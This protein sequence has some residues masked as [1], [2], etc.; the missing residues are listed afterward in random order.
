MKRTFTFGCSFTEYFW[1]T[2]ADIILYDNNGFNLGISGGGYDSIL[3]RMTEADRVFKFTPDDN[4]IIV[5]T[6]PLRW[7][8]TGSNQWSANGQV[9]N[10]KVFEKY[11]DE[12]FTFETL[13]FQS[14]HNMVLIND[15]LKHK[16]FN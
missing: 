2:W 3:Y 14:Y 12:F 1:P 5:F 8:L 4:V 11:F 9:Y 16:K 10:N 6:T 13:L 7:D 15:F